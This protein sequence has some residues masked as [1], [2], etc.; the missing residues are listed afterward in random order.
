MRRSRR[1]CRALQARLAHNAGISAACLRALM[2]LRSRRSHKL[3]LRRIE[4]FIYDPPENS[5][6]DVA[7]PFGLPG[8][9]Y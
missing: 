2:S 3:R 1:V 6:R 8:S 5:R 9:S 4:A 7:V